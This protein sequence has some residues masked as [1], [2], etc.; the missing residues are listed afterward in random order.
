MLKKQTQ[1]FV[2]FVLV[3]PIAIGIM[4]S[5]EGCGDNPNPCDRK[6]KITAE[7]VVG[8]QFLGVDTVILGDTILAGSTVVFRAS[9]NDEYQ[10]YEWKI[11]DDPRKFN[12]KEVGLTFSSDLFFQPQ[13]V[14]VSLKVQDSFLQNCFPLTKGRDSVTKK[15]VIVPQRNSVVFG[16]FEGYLEESPNNKFVVNIR[17]CNP[18]NQG[19]ICSNNIDFGCDNRLYN[20]DPYPFINN[21]TYS[22]RALHIGDSKSPIFINSASGHPGIN[23]ND[24]LGWL[25]FGKSKNQVFINYSSAVYPNNKK[26]RKHKF[27]GKRI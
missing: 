9:S 8:A 13:S 12:T 17:Y 11:G 23:C 16:D 26:R 2:W 21:I 22:Y 3:V 7:F 4:F 24:P 5:L 10:F 25:Y 27:I 15:I 18:N 1:F 19:F 20:S 14:E 6:A